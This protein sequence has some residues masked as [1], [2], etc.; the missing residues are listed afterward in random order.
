MSALSNSVLRRDSEFRIPTFEQI[1]DTLAGK[2]PGSIDDLKAVLLDRLEIV[3]DYIRNGDTDAWEAFWDKDAP[4]D[5]NTCRDRLLDHLRPQIPI[6][7]NFLL[8]ITMPEANRADIVAIYREYGLP[9]E[10]K[11]QWH[12][13]LWDAASVQLIEKYARD[14]RADDRGIY[15]ILWFGRVARKNL[16]KHPE[17]LS[18]P[19]SPDELREMLI[20]RLAP[21]ERARIE[22]F[23]LDVSKP[24]T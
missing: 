14:W 2:L 1:K 19:K 15:L 21:A 13:N 4:K 5:E 20:A 16:V 12:S 8:E 22:V 24:Q 9:V 23:V 17:G 10:I 3:Q 6:E 7:I 18:R 11:G